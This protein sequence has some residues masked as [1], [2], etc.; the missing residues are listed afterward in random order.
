M[1]A[2][3]FTLS[4]N[5]VYRSGDHDHDHAVQTVLEAVG[6]GLL[7]RGR[8][9]LQLDMSSR[10]FPRHTYLLITATPVPEN[11]EINASKSCA[12]HLQASKNP[13]EA[14]DSS[15]GTCHHAY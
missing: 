3:F 4:D 12:Q 10:L 14:Q 2:L 8:I 5:K 7:V 1:T 13:T 9:F 6:L 11:P 15:T